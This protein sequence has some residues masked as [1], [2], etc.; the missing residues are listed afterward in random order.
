VTFIFDDGRGNFGRLDE[1]LLFFVSP[2]LWLAV[3]AVMAFELVMLCRDGEFGLDASREM[4]S[5]LHIIPWPVRSG[6]EVP[7]AEGQSLIPA[8][9]SLD[10]SDI[11]AQSL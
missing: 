11:A 1:L 3:N 6:N 7:R 10:A 2:V 9:S 8:A 5:R 4:E